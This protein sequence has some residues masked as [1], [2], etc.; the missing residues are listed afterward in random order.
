MGKPLLLRLEKLPSRGYDGRPVIRWELRRHPV[1]ATKPALV[2]I[3][4]AALPALALALATEHHGNQPIGPGWKFPADVL[5]VA[6]LPSRVYWREL[7][8]DPHFFFHGDVEALNRALV[9]FARIGGPIEILLLPGPSDVRTLSERKPVPCDWE[10]HAP[11]GDYASSA[12]QEK[13]TDVMVKHPRLTIYVSAAGPHEQV[14]DVQLRR[15]IADLDSDSFAV[16]EKASRELE[17]L[18]HAAAPALRRAKEDRPSP[19]QLRRIRELLEKLEGIDLD[20]VRIPAGLPVLTTKDLHGRYLD[21]LKV[22]DYLIRGQ[23]AVGLG[24]LGRHT[25]E[26]IP[27]LVSVLQTDRHEYVRRC[28]ASVL[29]HLGQRARAALPVL[30]EGLQDPDVSV[31]NSFQAAIEM[32]E[33]PKA[34]QPTPE[35]FDRQRDLDRRI[36]RFSEGIKGGNP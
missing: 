3:L 22:T 20:L 11:G 21:G 8:G 1:T 25:D 19:E 35:H 18:G 31:R 5:A 2:L 12:Q 16:R 10:L 17:R 23:A 33:N 7:N 30:R 26:V 29:G 4:L 9:Q 24:R 34:A 28:T 32:I 27:T 36:Q 13:G 6:N 14:D 15:W